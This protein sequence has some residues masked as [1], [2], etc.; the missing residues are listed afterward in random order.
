[1]HIQI[2]NVLSNTAFEKLTNA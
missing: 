1:M 2:T